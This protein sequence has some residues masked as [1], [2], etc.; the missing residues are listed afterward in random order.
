MLAVIP[1]LHSPDALSF[2]P[3][4]NWLVTDLGFRAK[5]L[6]FKPPSFQI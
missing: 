5:I 6:T 3:Y 4:N 1:S 2:A